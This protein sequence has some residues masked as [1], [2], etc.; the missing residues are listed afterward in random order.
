MIRDFKS[1]LTWTYFGLF[2]V[3]QNLYLGSTLVVFDWISEIL[4]RLKVVC[5]SAL[6]QCILSQVFFY[7]LPLSMLQPSSSFGHIACPQPQS[8]VSHCHW[9][10]SSSS[11]SPFPCALAYNTPKP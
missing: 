1:S 9:F 8:L 4:R 6:S 11:E 10:P 7:S 2:S 3:E 5:I